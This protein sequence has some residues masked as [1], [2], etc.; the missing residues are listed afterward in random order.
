MSINQYLMSATNH[1]FIKY[2][3][4]GEQFLQARRSGSLITDMKT[5]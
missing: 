1:C 3:N 5:F 2:T 4:H